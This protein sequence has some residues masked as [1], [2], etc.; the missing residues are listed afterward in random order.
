MR[1]ALIKKKK[2]FWQT[3]FDIN[4]GPKRNLTFSK[5]NKPYTNTKQTFYT[6]SVF[7]YETK[8]LFVVVFWLM[9]S[10]NMNNNVKGTCQ[11]MCPE[12]EV[13]L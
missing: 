10:G 9:I 8:K 4:W 6:E 13:L 7:F 3:N 12:S 11:E 1:S 5:V 2:N